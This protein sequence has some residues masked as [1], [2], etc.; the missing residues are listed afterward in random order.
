MTNYLFLVMK[1]L[2][3]T[4]IQ[5]ELFWENPVANM[6]MLEE[7]I[8][9]LSDPGDI[10]ILPEMFN[11]GF[12]MNVG[13]IAEPM[14][15]T[16]FKWMKQQAAS[17]NSVI[18]GS[19]I[20]KDHD[21]FFNRLIWMQP[22]GDYRFYDKKHLFRMGEEHDHFSSG[23]RKLVIEWKGWKICPMVC[24]DL[25]FP[26]WSRNIKLEYDLLI[27]VANWPAARSHA[28]K[29]LLQARAIENLSYVAGVNRVGTDGKG[30]HYS[31][32]S[33]LIDFKGE[34]LFLKQNEEMIQTEVLNKEALIDFRNKFPAN[35]DADDFQML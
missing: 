17:T 8:S 5:T 25:R 11:S 19:I 23:N 34:A 29:T 32:D 3:I 14:N 30:L 16:T 35:L 15:L 12:T 22:D 7:K 33:A 4:L 20:V 21:R 6:A 2:S 1:N 31:G 18:L 9:Q 24:Y 26:V 28:W 27:Y 10:I 13:K